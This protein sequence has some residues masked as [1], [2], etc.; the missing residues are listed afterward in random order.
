MYDVLSEKGGTL[1]V[2]IDLGDTARRVSVLVLAVDG[3]A[4]SDESSEGGQLAGLGGAVSRGPAHAHANRP[5]S[6]ELQ[7]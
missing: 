7:Q 2:S 5:L 4:R 6:T 1:L 3:D